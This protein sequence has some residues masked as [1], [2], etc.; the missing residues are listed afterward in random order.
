M[1]NGN[2]SYFYFQIYYIREYVDWIKVKNML[3]MKSESHLKNN[4]YNIYMSLL[5]QLFKKKL[6]GPS[7][8]INQYNGNSKK[9]QFVTS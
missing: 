2:Q 5:Y 4:V 9:F 6:R 3:T 7:K 8:Q 1:L